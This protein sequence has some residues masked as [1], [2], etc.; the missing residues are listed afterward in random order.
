M[1]SILTLVLAYIAYHRFLVQQALQ[2]Q[3]E[4]VLDLIKVIHESKNRVEI[5]VGGNILNTIHTFSV[6]ELLTQRTFQEDKNI[7][8]YYPE[9]G[10][11][12][13]DFYD[14]FYTNPLLPVSIAARLKKFSIANKSNYVRSSVFNRNAVIIGNT[15]NAIP[16]TRVFY[17]TD[18]LDDP[19]NTTKNFKNCVSDLKQS[20]L[21][22]LN[23]YGIS[24]VNLL[25]GKNF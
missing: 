11:L 23:D 1:V 18:R 2:K 12:S 13:W 4:V 8:F 9:D 14:K 24:S 17:V 20:I 6:F 22:W 25:E 21:D 16:M 7:Y 3:L 15:E 5:H 19:L 10:A